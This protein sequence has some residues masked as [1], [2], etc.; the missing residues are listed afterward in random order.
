MGLIATRRTCGKVRCAVGDGVWP[1]WSNIR[2]IL[3]QRTLEVNIENLAAITDGQDRFRRSKCMSKNGLVGPVPIGI[4]SL[5]LRV[6]GSAI[7]AGVHVSRATRQYKGIQFFQLLRQLIRGLFQRDF[8]RF[9][10]SFSYGPEIEIQLVP[11]AMVLFLGGAPGDA[12]TGA[13]G[14]A[15]LGISRD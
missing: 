11:S 5:C 15:R 1:I 6:P 7:A 9:S 2:N 4:Q 8:Q 14:D 12:H 10:A 3:N 13:V